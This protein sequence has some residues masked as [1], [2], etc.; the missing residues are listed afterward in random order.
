MNVKRTLLRNAPYALFI[1]FTHFSLLKN[2]IHINLIPSFG[3]FPTLD[4]LLRPIA[5]SIRSFPIF[6]A[7]GEGK[8]H[9]R[10][11][12]QMNRAC[13][14]MIQFFEYASK[15]T[16]DSRFGRWIFA[17]FLFILTSFPYDVNQIFG[18]ILSNSG[19]CYHY[20]IENVRI[21]IS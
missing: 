19:R 9:L 10:N 11:I 21:V 6:Q 8:F 1:P 13:R 2:H 18:D 3:N 12:P 20:L 16:K 5:V 17:L 14:E 4:L 15:K 7:N